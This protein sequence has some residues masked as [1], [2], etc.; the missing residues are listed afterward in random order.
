MKIKS[1]LKKTK[2][3]FCE[4]LKPGENDCKTISLKNPA[5]RFKL[6]A[7]RDAGVVSFASND[8]LKE[9]DLPIPLSEEVAARKEAEAVAA[10]RLADKKAKRAELREKNLKAEQKPSPKK[11]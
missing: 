5:Q 8:K 9:S 10:K 3:L 7:M 4:Q 11:K 6:L 2:M 1:N